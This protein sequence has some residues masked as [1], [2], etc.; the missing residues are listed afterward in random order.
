[1]KGGPGNCNDCLLQIDPKTGDL[2]QSYGSVNHT[3][4]FG[5]AFWAGTAYGFDN[6]GQMFSIGWQNNKLVTTDLPVPNP[7]PGLQF[8]GAGSTT[9]AP[10]TSQDGGGI[11]IQ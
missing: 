10:P 5:L 2:V 6:G 7:P 1:M 11:P 9:A 8:W 4:V 3:D